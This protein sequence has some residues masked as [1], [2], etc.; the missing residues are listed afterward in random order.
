MISCCCMRATTSHFARTWREAL[1]LGVLVEK[2]RHVARVRVHVW[3]WDVLERAHH[4]ADLLHTAIAHTLAAT[5]IV[6]TC[7]MQLDLRS[8]TV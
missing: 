2:P 8:Q 4:F 5:V 6:V 7:E 1:E 3:R